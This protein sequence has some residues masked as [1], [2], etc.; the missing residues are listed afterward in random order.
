MKQIFQVPGYLTG[1]Q[2]KLSSWKITYEIDDSVINADR[3]A[4]FTEL[5][6][7]PSWLTINSHVIEA[8]DIIDLPPIRPVEPGEKTPSQRLR[9]VLAVM[10]KQNNEGFKTVDEHYKY[11]IEKFIN[12]IKGKLDD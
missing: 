9:A 6:G 5:K 10:F 1:I 2:S 4:R 3:I 8:E 12:H 7:K 11:Y